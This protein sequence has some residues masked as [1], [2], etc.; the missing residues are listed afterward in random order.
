MSTP[1]TF[2]NTYDAIGPMRAPAIVFLHGAT[3][4]RKQWMPQFDALSDAYRV[5]AVDLPGHGELAHERFTL[6]DAAARVEQIIRER[7]PYKCALVVGR[8][9]QSSHSGL[10]LAESSASGESPAKALCQALKT[11]PSSRQ[12]PSDNA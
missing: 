1:Q 8:W 9:H 10:R 2:D 7:T 12:S 11:T 6:D 3:A 5:I 4:T